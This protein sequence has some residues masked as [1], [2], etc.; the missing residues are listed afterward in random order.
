MNY[1]A[2][3]AQAAE[4]VRQYMQEHHDPRFFYHNIIH[5][6][7]VVSASSQLA[8]HYQ[9]NEE[10][11]F[12][13]QTAAWFHDLGYCVGGAPGHELRSADM[14]DAFLKDKNVREDLITAIKNCILA[15][16]MPQHPQTLNEQI[17]CDA[18]LFH[19]GTS[20]FSERNKLM[21]K[22]TAAVEN[23]EINKESWRKSSV[24]FMQQQHYWTDYS[25]LL[26]D[27]K[28]NENIE[29]LLKKEIPE[30]DPLTELIHK[31]EEQ[32]GTAPAGGDM[33]KKKKQKKPKRGI[34]TVFRISSGANQR[35]STQADNKAHIMIQVNSIIISVVFSLMLRNLDENRNLQIPAIMLILVN[36]ITIVFSVL[37]TRPRI[38]GGKFEK[39]DIDEKKVNL[40][41]FGNF[42]KMSL[43]EYASGMLKMMDDS[44]FLYGSLIRNVYGQGVV[45]GRKYFLLRVSYNV[46]MYGLIA[47]VIAFIVA[48]TVFGK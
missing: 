1:V 30:T 41:F 44:D 11:F 35:L 10:D 14:A 8:N 12:V 7:N 45:L 29:K 20:D 38:P 2:L 18:D 22:E 40:L 27:A 3:I 43:E 13:V 26:L 19:F 6:E 32:T 5:T 28:K 33:P 25:R 23:K 47:S 42:Y 34:E 21:R 39:A 24:A 4:H 48:V 15:T 9:L 31:Y 17:V 16:R 46:F 36:V 37:A